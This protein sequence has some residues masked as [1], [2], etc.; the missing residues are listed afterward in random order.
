[1]VFQA[2]IAKFE[3]PTMFS[4]A[5]SVVDFGVLQL[6]GSTPPVPTA[7]GRF[8]QPGEE[9]VLRCLCGLLAERDW[10][11]RYAAV[12]AL[13]QVPAHPVAELAA[14]TSPSV[15]GQGGCFCRAAR[16]WCTF[17]VRALLQVS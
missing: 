2:R 11:V 5:P 3:L 10:D 14:L 12:D 17:P 15:P 16:R 7:P 13:D 9:R 6:G 4:R 1:M 8:A